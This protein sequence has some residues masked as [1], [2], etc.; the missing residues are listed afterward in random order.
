MQYKTLIDVP[1]LS[2]NLGHP[3]W[4][5]FDCRAKVVLDDDLP[6]RVEI[7]L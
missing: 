4:A 7:G 2:A 5:L 3:D 6:P 1:T